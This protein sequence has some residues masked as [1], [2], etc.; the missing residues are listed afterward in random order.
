MYCL[1]PVR[2]PHSPAEGRTLRPSRLLPVA[3]VPLLP[4]SNPGPLL[5]SPPAVH[6]SESI[7]SLRRSRVT[8]DWQGSAGSV[9]IGMKKRT[10]MF[11]R[12]SLN[13]RW[14]GVGLIVHPAAGWAPMS[15]VTVA[16][17]G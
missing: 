3:A 5:R 11:M 2:E 16:A 4:G 15:H 13:P 6:G 10:T 17:L 7:A 12:R 8:F 1:L 9:L 14:F